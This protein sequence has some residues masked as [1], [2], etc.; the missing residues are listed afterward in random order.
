MLPESGLCDVKGEF[1][2]GGWTAEVKRE[3][4]RDAAA[5]EGL[6]TEQT[7]GVGESVCSPR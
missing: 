5:S 3:Q 1:V 4:A 2:D 7:D 6:T